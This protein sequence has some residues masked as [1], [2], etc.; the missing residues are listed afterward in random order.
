MTGASTGVLVTAFGYIRDLDEIPEYLARISR[1]EPGEK[2]VAALRERYEAM[3]GAGPLARNTHEQVDA[4]ARVLGPEYR[5]VLGLRNSPPFIPD[6]AEELA[7][8]GVRRIV[9]IAL[10]P[11]YGKQ[12]VEGYHDAARE[13]FARVPDAPPAAFVRSYGTHPQLIAYWADELRR[14]SARVPAEL[15]DAARV[16]FTA[17]SVPFA[18]LFDPPVYPGECEATARAVAEAAGVDLYELAYQSGHGADWLGPDEEEVLHALAKEGVPAVVFAPVG[19]V[20]EHL[21]TIYDLDIAAGGVAARLGIRL[22]R[23]QAP[24]ADPR[25]IAALAE[26][27]RAHAEQV[28][29]PE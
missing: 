13:G 1:S 19:F 29:A 12:S 2:A 20:A 25:F 4:L 3:G 23:A 6:V 11:Q 15:R 27:V 17:H 14:A 10:A 26:T 7:R 22:A 28:R 24:N 21:E 9:A 5:V 18:E 16:V 8:S